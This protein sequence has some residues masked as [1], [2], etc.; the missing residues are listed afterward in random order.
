MTSWLGSTLKKAEALLESV[1]EKIKD[2]ATP[3]KKR[4][5]AAL[6]VVPEQDDEDAELQRMHESALIERMRREARE[7]QARNERLVAEAREAAAAREAAERLLLADQDTSEAELQ[8]I[9]QL[10]K[11]VAQAKE[12]ATSLARRLEDSREREREGAR[13]REAAAG[14]VAQLQAL[15]GVKEMEV[16]SA[17][18]KVV[19]LE[20]RLERSRAVIESLQV[21]QHPP[22]GLAPEP[23]V[24]P[25]YSQALQTQISELSLALAEAR[26]DA[27]E[28]E[29]RAATLR[30]KLAEQWETA[31]KEASAQLAL[32]K[33]AEAEVRGLRQELRVE[34]DVNRG[35]K[36]ELDDVRN[37]LERAKLS[38]Q[39]RVELSSS[40]TES[41]ARLKKVTEALL[42]KQQALDLAN[43]ER[44]TLLLQLDLVK[45]SRAQYEEQMHHSSSNN[46]GRARRN[47]ASAVEELQP[48][49]GVV[50]GKF[51]SAANKLDS[52]WTWA[53]SRAR[54][55]RLRL[56]VI[57]YLFVLQLVMVIFFLHFRRHD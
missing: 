57:L 21:E 7:Q 33:A 30:A 23:A 45:R 15:V 13:E 16:E 56:V 26:Q 37:E 2:T 11:D 22:A 10:R 17:R 38:I 18:Q 20:T 3:L 1:D 40:Q 39:R 36:H 42:A 12:E 24:P 19:A 5:A 41:E 29:E 54:S 9:V 25:P 51:G 14:R 47:S 48:I 52:V 44:A 28:T 4:D 43:S 27:E 50:P 49:S 55:P 6:E 8:K 53:Q 34:K 31:S 35:L 46:S 32:R